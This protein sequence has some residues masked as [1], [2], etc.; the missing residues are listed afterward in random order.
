MAQ[1]LKADGNVENVTPKNGFK[2]SLDE[3][4]KAVGGYIELVYLPDGILV[5]NEEGKVHG[6]PVNMLATDLVQQER[7][8]FDV[9]VG[10]ALLCDMSEMD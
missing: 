4:Q 8:A 1:L 3:M 6:L 5:V 10:D 2:F 9:I 7:G